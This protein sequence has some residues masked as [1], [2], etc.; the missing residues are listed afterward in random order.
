VK[1]EASKQEHNGCRLEK[2]KIKLHTSGGS[3]CQKQVQ[4]SD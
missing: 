4:R 3:G 2:K 1:A